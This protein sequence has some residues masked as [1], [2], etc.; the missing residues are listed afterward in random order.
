MVNIRNFFKP[1]KEENNESI[2][3]LRAPGA[4]VV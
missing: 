2:D 3:R 4:K 1:V